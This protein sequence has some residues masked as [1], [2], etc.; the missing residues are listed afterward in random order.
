MSAPSS[1]LTT[2]GDADPHGGENAWQ[3]PR[4]EAFVDACG[5][6][7]APSTDQPGAIAAP[8]RRLGFPTWRDPDRYAFVARR[9]WPV[10]SVSGPL[11]EE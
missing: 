11:D 4:A 5:R 8:R 1:S 6:R 3:A 10:S 7:A 2:P 9:A